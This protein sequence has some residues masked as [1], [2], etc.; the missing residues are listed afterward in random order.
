MGGEKVL[1]RSGENGRLNSTTNRTPESKQLMVEILDAATQLFRER[2]FL[3]TTTQELADAVGLVKGTLYYHIGSKDELLYRIHEQVTDEGIARW[4]AI[5]E[6]NQD[7]PAPEVLRQM[8]VEHCRVIDEYRDW[9]AVF[10]EEMKHLP[11]ELR[12]RVR[13]KRAEYQ[14]IFEDAV[15]RGVERAELVTDDAHLTALV[16]LGML[17]A[18]YRWYSPKGRLTPGRIGE[19][20]ASIFLDGI[21]PASSH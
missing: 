1:R 10:S 15:R 2:G 13:A 4:K 9:V 8:I 12:D 17:N 16:A 19:I 5:V 18:I 6:A 11:R 7:T 3:G 20:V 21:R 14:K